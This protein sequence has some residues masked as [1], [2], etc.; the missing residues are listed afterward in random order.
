MPRSVPTTLRWVFSVIAAVLAVGLATLTLLL[1][2]FQQSVGDES[3]FVSSADD[4]IQEESFRSDLADAA[5]QQIMDSDSVQQYVGDGST[6]GGLPGLQSWA[7]D[8]A[9]GLMHSTVKG[10]VDSE[11]FRS[12][13][14]QT[15]KETHASNFGDDPSST[16][17]VDATPIYQAVND[18][19]ENAVHIDLGLGDDTARIELEEGA[20]AHFLHT[21]QSLAAVA[22]TFGAV[23]VVAALVS[24]LV[25]PRGKSLFVALVAAATGLV[26]WVSMTVLA[27]RFH[28]Q[29]DTVEGTGGLIAQH[30]GDALTSNVQ[31]WALTSLGVGLGIALILVIIHVMDASRHTNESHTF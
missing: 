19:V 7:K 20:M 17:V 4:V 3:H 8:R 26:T 1:A 25:A 27:S 9:F 12:T 24:A 14:K 6:I 31:A 16:L 22:P 5:T 18:K 29:L 23:A 13:W 21:A 11:D 15:A 2:W 10:V 28:A 30:M